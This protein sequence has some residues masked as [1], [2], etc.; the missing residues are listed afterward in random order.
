MNALQLVYLF[1]PVQ[2]NIGIQIYS[3]CQQH[4]GSISRPSDHAC[5]RPYTFSQLFATFSTN[6]PISLS[7]ALTTLML[8]IGPACLVP[9]TTQPKPHN[10]SVSDPHVWLRYK[11]SAIDLEQMHNWL[12]GSGGQVPPLPLT[13]PDAHRSPLPLPPLLLPTCLRSSG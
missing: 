9:P 7:S 1:L 8:F 11:Q 12:T 3:T 5:D 2:Y 6:G 4:S 10:L 13:L